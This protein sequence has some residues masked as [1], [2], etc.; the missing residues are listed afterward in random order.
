MS[1]YVFSLLF[2]FSSVFCQ[3]N[4]KN[5]AKIQELI[6]NLPARTDYALLIY[7]PDNS[8]TIFSKNISKPLIPASNVKIFTA[9]AAYHYLGPD[10]RIRTRIS[11]DNFDPADSVVHGN[12]YI[13]GGGN[14]LFSSS[15]LD[16]LVNEII[17]NGINKIEGNIVG[18]D[19]FFDSL[20]SRKDWI[21]E[22]RSNLS[23]PPV[24]A[25]TLNRNEIFVTVESGKK[26]GEELK[27]TTDPKSSFIKITNSAKT[28]KFRAK[29]RISGRISDNKFVLRVSGGMWIKSRARRYSVFIESPPLFAAMYVYD[30]LRKAGIKITGEP[31]KG[32]TPDSS[33]NIA[34]HGLP[35]FQLISRMNKKS[36]NFLA[37]CLFKIIGAE[38][39]GKKGNSFYS[40]QAINKMLADYDMSDSTEIVDGS[41]I[42]RNNHTTVSTISGLLEYIYFKDDIFNDFYNSLAIAGADGTLEDRIQTSFAKHNFHGKTG[43]LNGV[44]SLSGYLTTEKG[45]NL[46]VSII[47]NYK[48]GYAALYKN[49][50]DLII[51]YLADF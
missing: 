23:L 35:M 13:R 42:S 32:I 49:T 1:R 31:V 9:A 46:I 14:G 36:D 41:G 2:L 20:Y 30:K 34:E 48:N 15:D 17:A 3:K 45:N 5:D 27:V 24:S 22:E 18:D 26:D 19:T 47:F 37:E 16:S 40:S 6:N 29:P 10:Y 38:F 50:E 7:N 8:D 43:T 25:L 4:V 28:T 39:I 33:E 21:V 11:C 12:L 51:E 44:S